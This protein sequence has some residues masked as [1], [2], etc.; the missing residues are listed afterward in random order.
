M[1]KSDRGSPD[2][3]APR[4]LQR[5]TS[6]TWGSAGG[7][8]RAGT[9]RGGGGNELTSGRELQGAEADKGIDSRLGV[10]GVQGREGGRRRGES[11]VGSRAPV[12]E[13]WGIGRPASIPWGVIGSRASPRA[14]LSSALMQVVGSR[15]DR[16]MPTPV[17]T[18]KLP[19]LCRP[20]GRSRRVR[21]TWEG[22]GEGS[23]EDRGVRKGGRKREGDKGDVLSESEAHA[24]ASEGEG[25][26][27]PRL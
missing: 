8:G 18:T 10:G 7:E 12:G 27:D 11:G 17:T 26:E 15:L 3:S 21:K 2:F 13:R 9:R 23:V 16:L 20:V 24:G 22:A 5:R 19:S 25:E 6:E 4:G 1:H 14:P